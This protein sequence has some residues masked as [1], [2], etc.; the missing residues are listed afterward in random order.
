MGMPAS[1]ELV[2]S[3]DIQPIEHIFDLWDEIN[4]RFSTYRD[5]SEVAH[6]NRGNIAPS[7]HSREM[8]EVLSL[9]EKT[10]RETAGYFN[11][12]RPDGTFDP[13]GIVKGW[14]IRKAADLAKASGFDSYYLEIGGDIQTNGHNAEGKEWTIGIRNPFNRE[15]IVKVLYPRGA[16]VATSGTAARG[17]HIYN[18][19]DPR[20]PI[21]DI[22]SL[23]VVGPDVCEADRFA[24]A[25]FAMG[26]SGIDF[27]EKLEGF[28]G[29]SIDSAGIATLTSGL[30]SHLA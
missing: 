16:G 28:E 1:V 15:Q 3:D 23:T 5:D 29:Y 14:A 18:P 22:V 10:M 20:V 24:T 11:V 30:G 8:Q 4:A 21:T 6:I 12:R 7:N 17:N 19:H 13:S 26:R 25:A 27:I 2:G 9:A